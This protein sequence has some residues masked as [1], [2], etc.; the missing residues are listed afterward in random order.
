MDLSFEIQRVLS[1]IFVCFLIASCGSGDQSS[2]GSAPPPS[3]VIDP[4]PTTSQLDQS[5]LAAVESPT[6]TSASRFL[7]AASFG[8]TLDSINQLVEQGYSD[9][10]TTQYG[11]PMNSLVD[12]S[13]PQLAATTSNRLEHYA[14]ISSFYENAIMGQDQLRM[15]AT[16]ALSQILVVSTYESDIIQSDGEGLAGYMDILQRGAFGNYRDLLEEVTYSPIMGEYLTYAGNRKGDPSTGSAPDEN[17][18]REIMQLFTIGLYELNLDGTV[19]LNSNGQPIETYTN[20]DITELARVFTGLWW[21][22]GEFGLRTNTYRTPSTSLSRMKMH[23]DFHDTGEKVILGQ[24]I[25]ADVL[26]TQAISAALDILFEHPNIAPFISQQLIQRLTTSNPSPEY[27]ER[28]ATAFNN[29]QYFMPN[30]VV[31]GSGDRGSLQAVWAA[32][33]MDDEFHNPESFDSAT[34]GKVREPVLRFTHW[35]RMAGVSEVSI[36][37]LNRAVG[38]DSLIDPMVLDR[39]EHQ[40]LGQRPFT[41]PTVFNFFRPGYAAMGSESKLA[42]LVAPE[43]QIMTDSTVVAYANFIRELILRDPG[44]G[45]NNGPYGIVGDYANEI[46]VAENPDDLINHL[47]LLLTAGSMSTDTRQR[48]HT[49]IAATETSGANTNELLRE[50]VQHAILLIAVSPEFLVQK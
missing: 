6:K 24:S 38:V 20:Q 3:S 13:M 25:S 18:A 2:A 41:S 7:A 48:L 11:L 1:A 49:V 33:L 10:I 45:G 43:L 40:R 5:Q 22:G 32:I 16:F 19:K 4:L 30:G 34:F 35:A 8:P 9:W 39:F 23:L 47:D 46:A 50:R 31:V 28:V 36:I 26:G 27:V 15:R 21:D 44:A 17:F 42:G 37:E 12:R 29:G 14:P